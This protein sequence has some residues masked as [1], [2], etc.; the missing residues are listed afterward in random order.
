MR[1]RNILIVG[2]LLACLLGGCE[3]PEKPESD[4]MLPEVSTG[5]VTGITF[6]TA[7]VGGTVTNDGGYPVETRGVCWGETTLPTI[8]DRK[9]SAGGGKGEFECWLAGLKTGMVY[10]VRA[11][12]TNKLGT[13]YGD[14]VSFTTR[15]I[16]IPFV[17]SG[18]AEQI[19]MTSA[20]LSGSVAYDGGATVTR[21]GFCYMNGEG[22]PTIDNNISDNGN[23]IGSFKATLTNLEP[24]TTY[25][26]CAFA[27]NS[28]GTGYSDT[29]HFTTKNEGQSEYTLDDYLGTYTIRYKSGDETTYSTYSPVEI[30]PFIDENGTLWVYITGFREGKSHFSAYG[31]WNASDQCIVLQGG[32]YNSNN[33]FYFNNEPGVYYCAVFNPV[34]YDQ[35]S[36]VFYYLYGGDADTGEAKLMKNSDGTL[37]YKAAKADKNDRVANGFTYKVLFSLNGRIQ[38]LFQCLLGYYSYS[39]LLPFLAGSKTS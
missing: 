31:K 21:R 22:T 36:G 7:K 17:T 24:N 39:F 25:S 14:A 37:S 18:T 33:T 28:A 38:R 3:E 10:Y 26:Y 15:S 16:E 4:L 6:E 29:K 8:N 23:G 2:T 30:Q 11:F 34:F 27:I 19:T 20:E 5:L 13:Q 32:Y 1:T 35:N 12:A 9:L